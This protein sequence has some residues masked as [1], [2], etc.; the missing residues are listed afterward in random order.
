MAYIQS[1]Y[2]G[3]EKQMRNITKVLQDK[4]LGTTLNV[5]V[6]EQLIPPFEVTEKTEL[7]PQEEKKIRESAAA[8]CGGNDQEC[9]NAK[10]AQLR[11]DSLAVKERA[12]N[13]SATVIKGRRLTV[14]VVDENNKVRRLVIPDGQKFK[15]DKIMINDPRK[16][17][18]QLPKWETI[19][20]QFKLMAG[21]ILTTAVYVFGVVATYTVFM[22]AFEQKILFVIPLVAISIFIPFSG[23]VMIFLY[24]LFQ[25][26]LK[27]YLG[28][29]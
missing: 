24:Y 13:S 16:G 2:Y 7:T 12:S 4:I 14:N 27:R 28:E 23:Y 6:N 25:G 8:Q 21:L 15:L 10:E 17:G 19:Q 9:I 29:V 1:A 5:D 22:K 3:D 18:T 26:A 11:Q 20:N